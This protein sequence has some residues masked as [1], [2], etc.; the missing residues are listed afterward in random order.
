MSH[1]FDRKDMQELYRSRYGERVIKDD[2]RVLVWKESGLVTERIRSEP[3]RMIGL[4][5]GDARLR[6]LLP[7]PHPFDSAL[8]LISE[9]ATPIGSPALIRPTREASSTGSSRQSDGSELS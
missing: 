8:N 1:A 2:V 4:L 3:G 9:Q 7:V 5:E 6:F